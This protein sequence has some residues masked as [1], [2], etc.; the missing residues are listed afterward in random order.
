MQQPVPAPPRRRAGPLVWLAA[1]ILL[2]ALTGAL[3]WFRVGGLVLAATLAGVAVARAV[4]PVVSAGPL[5]VRSRAVDVA[6][7]GTLAVGVGLLAL[8]APAGGY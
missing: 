3:V 5:A 2:A 8:L 1:G 6:T 4:L 7:A